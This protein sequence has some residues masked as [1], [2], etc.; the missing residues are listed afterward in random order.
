MVGSDK[1]GT[2]VDITAR[3]AQHTRE[4]VALVG[5]LLPPLP[6]IEIF[7]ICQTISSYATNHLS[8]VVITRESS[9]ETTISVSWQFEDEAGDMINFDATD[10]AVLESK[11]ANGSTEFILEI[12]GNAC[13]VDLVEMRYNNPRTGY[14]GRIDRRTFSPDRECF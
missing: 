8:N 14:I 2:T 9:A 10:V 7:E 6:K 11:R 4:I 1:D 3:P 13:I 12:V 5:E